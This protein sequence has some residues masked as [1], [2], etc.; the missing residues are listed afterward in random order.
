MRPT[1]EYIKEKF[2][3]YNRDMFGGQL[4]EVPIDIVNV[5]G[6]LGMCSYKKR[7]GD[8]GNDEYYDFKLSINE[9]LDVSEDELQDTLIHEMIHYYIGFNQLEDSSSHGPVFLSMMN[10]INTKFGRNITVSH[11]TTKRESQG[12]IDTRR[13]WH[14]VATIEVKDGA[15]GIKV[16]P[17]IRDRIIGFVNTVKSNAE[18]CTVDLY[19]TDDPFFNRFPTS[20]STKFQV[21]NRE[22][23]YNNLK[24]ARRLS[25]HNG[26]LVGM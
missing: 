19:M 21:V 8:N 16:L 4:P 10:I 5:K 25:I 1:L 3:E 23:V 2:E 12:L 13:H 15:F 20:I 7:C 18:I 22:E 24:G 6:Y 26:D 9:R 17:R 14:V 11:K